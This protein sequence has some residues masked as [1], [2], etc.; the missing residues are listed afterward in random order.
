VASETDHITLANRNH[1]TLLYLCDDAEQHAEWVATVA[2]YK[3]VQVVEA[4][5]AN[6]LGRHSN[7]HDSRID[8]LKRRSEFKPLFKAYR[9]LYS[10]SLV[11]RYLEDSSPKKLDGGKSQR[12]KSFLD[13]MPGEAVIK[14]LLKKRLDV[15]EQHAVGFLSETGRN[16]LLRIGKAFGD[17]KFETTAQEASAE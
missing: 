15:L 12:Y 5:F 11:A 7:G 4:V 13:Y 8:D 6:H 1:G 9:P 17:A 3:A 16:S 14:R 2:F 10:A